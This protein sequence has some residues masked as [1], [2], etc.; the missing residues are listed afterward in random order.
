MDN[1]DNDAAGSVQEALV[2]D[3]RLLA[4]LHGS[5][6]AAASRQELAAHPFSGWMA[7]NLR[8]DKAQASFRLL[9]EGLRLEEGKTSTR[10]EDDL[11]A[12]FAAIYLTH[13]Y[14]AAPTE[15][16][17]LDEDGLERQEPMFA[18]RRWYERY[19]LRAE[20]WRKAPDDH[21]ALQL[22]FLA[23]LLDRPENKME[24]MVE[25][26]VFLDEHLLRWID[27][28]SGRVAA[29]CATPFYAGLALLT[30]AYLHEM[31]DIISRITGKDRHVVT[32]QP[33][34]DDRPGELPLSTYVPGTGPV[35]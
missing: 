16:V 9:D 28:F 30:S 1:P 5:E 34:G 24:M 31:R 27:R 3:L 23:H 2:Q 29:R 20:N 12:D 21:L 35:W 13:T 17:W 14:R 25:A 22:Q 4:F 18:V 11:A 32:D 15:S 8:G 7:L 6:L 33:P 26:G 10:L 19:G